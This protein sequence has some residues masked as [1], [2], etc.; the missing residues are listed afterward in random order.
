MAHT[1]AGGK[2]RQHK[3]RAGKRLGVKKFGGEEVDTGQ[4]ILRQRG[5]SVHPGKNVGY[6]RDYTLFAKTKGKVEFLIKKGESMVSVLS[7]GSV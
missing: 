5:L 3:Q 6:G 1:K 7:G 4:I 2:T